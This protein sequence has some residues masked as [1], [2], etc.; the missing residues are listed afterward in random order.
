MKYIIV[1]LLAGLSFDTCLAQV[2][3]FRKY[4]AGERYQYRITTESVRNGKSTGKSVAVSEHI[5]TKDS[6]GFS[7]RIRWL[8]KKVYEGDSILNQDSIAH[9]VAE[10]NISLSPS[11]KLLLPS[12]DNPGMVGEITDLNTFYV[13]ISP[14]L[15]AQKLTVR[16]K[17][18]KN[19][20]T[21]EGNF[22]DN[23]RI[24][25]GKDCMVVTQELLRD[26]GAFVELKTI[27]SPPGKSCMQLLADTAVKLHS[28][29]SINFQMIQKGGGE[30][31]NYFWGVESFE[32]TSKIEKRTGKIIEATMVNVL[33]LKMLYNSDPD[34]KKFDAAL[35]V[36]IRRVVRVELVGR[37]G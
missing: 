25:F 28:N 30:K 29:D 23:K 4:R 8:G 19:P 10:Y 17:L 12:L 9:Q 32:I 20:E 21:R 31:V 5:V 14:A 11:G 26:N 6:I 18:V 22:A 2:V 34:L 33:D 35:P 24:L 36:S 27:F 16:Q 1:L 37:N 15:N 3:P 7:E 13:A